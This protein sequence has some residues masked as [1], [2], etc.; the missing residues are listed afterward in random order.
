MGE[1]GDAKWRI[2]STG[3]SRKMYSVTSWK[4]KRNFR[5][6][7]RWAMFRSSPVTR[8]SR[9]TTSCPS[10]RS[11][12]DRW[13][14]RK[15]AAPVTTMRMDSRLYGSAAA[16]PGFSR[17]LSGVELGVPGFEDRAGL[18]RLGHDAALDRTDLDALRRVERAHALR[19]APGL[20]HERGIARADRRVRAVGLARAAVD[21]GVLNLHGHKPPPIPRRVPPA[22]AGRP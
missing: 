19:A 15:P 9:P 12:S 10:A 1:A 5:F 2:A 13:L 17:A 4:T 20:D 7:A 18:G 3:P 14:P 22:A 11:R 8:L 21:A 16:P 6:P